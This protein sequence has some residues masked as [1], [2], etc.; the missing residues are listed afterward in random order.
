MAK[1]T[2]K[3]GE[4]WTFTDASMQTREALIINTFE[5]GY[6]LSVLLHPFR[7]GPVRYEVP[8]MGGIMYADPRKINI[9]HTDAFTGFSRGVTPEALAEFRTRAAEG[10]GFLSTEGDGLTQ[11]LK[12]SQASVASMA[13]KI[14]ELTIYKTI[15]EQFLKACADAMQSKPAEEP[16][17]HTEPEKTPEPEVPEPEVPKPLTK[18]E[19]N[20]LIVQENQ[21]KYGLKQ[22]YIAVKLKSV[23]MKQVTLDRLIG[24]SD[25]CVSHWVRGDSKAHWAVLERIFPGI[26]KEAEEWAKNQEEKK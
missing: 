4:I 2:P 26:E 9:R 12:A 13:D 19:R 6:A 15:Y 24:R 8:G 22:S 1:A 14:K 17:P 5:D 16:K 21:K 3:P 10:I 20:R 18:V 11:Q 25:G 23:G 7:K